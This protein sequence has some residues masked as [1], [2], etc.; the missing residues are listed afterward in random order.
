MLPWQI[1]VLTNDAGQRA[2]PS[3]FELI[4]D[5]D[6]L[7]DRL[8]LLWRGTEQVME[9]LIAS[10]WS[11]LVPAFLVTVGAF[12]VTRTRPDIAFFYLL[13]WL[14]SALAVCYTYWVTPIF[15]LAGFEQRTGPRIVLGA[16]FVAAAGLAHLLQLAPAADP[17]SRQQAASP[18]AH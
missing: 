11:M 7:V 9:Q 4:D 3:P 8:D 13:A 1:W 16:A 12:S 2:T 17:A 18:T 15:D 10:S 6:Y 14:F 5:P